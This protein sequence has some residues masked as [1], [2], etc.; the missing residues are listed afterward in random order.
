[1]S[2]VDVS[3][4]ERHLVRLK[5]LVLPGGGVEGA[6]YLLFGSSRV[7]EDPW[8]RQSRQRFLS[9]DVVPIPPDEIESAGPDHITWST[10]SFVRLLK[11]A[12]D[13]GLV[14][15][16]VHSHPG[17]PAC[18]SEQDQRNE[19][20]LARLAR[21]RNGIETPLLSL[22]VSGDG[23]LCAQ[24]W[25]GGKSAE[26]AEIVR[27]VGRRL[28]LHGALSNARDEAF[29]RQALAL[30]DGVNRQ[31]RA[32]R[33]G[34]VGC[35]GTG[36]AT[37]MLLARLGVGQIVLFDDD[38]VESTNLNRL[39]GARQADADGMR[40]KVEVLAREIAEMG[41]G[42]RVVPMQ[43]WVGDP[44]CRDALKSCDV[45]FGC[46]DDNDGRLL[47]NRLAY[48][49]LIPVIDMG[50]AI[51][52][53]PEGGGVRELS[54][55]CTV[56]APGGACLLCRGI[57]DPVLARE[58]EL[59]RRDPQEYERR[60]REA[61]VRGG[62][63]PAPAVVTFTTATASMAIDELLQGL[64]NFRGGDGWAWQRVRRFDLMRDRSPGALHSEDCPI[65]VDATYWG[66]GDV[67]P[68]LD[69]IG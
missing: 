65:C 30:G 41:L 19:A 60:K 26:A 15:G 24:A 35:G 11:Q 18:F 69:R 31:L 12:K 1:M 67:D 50:L 54:G 47:L 38:I 66:L 16:I 55:R 6:A 36:S 53:E 42:V 10:A 59:H 23:K 56:L 57:A 62:G 32:L 8:D 21:N 52:P 29:A 51:E 25:L 7:D 58:E 17:G 13:E 45:I 61:Y 68:F 39:H 49:Y 34:I 40:P 2:R 48:F 14:A 20:E 27:V 44:R 3:L 22:L 46:T 5:E 63:N 64:S 4:Q 9:Y 43:K 28:V 33:V 37:A